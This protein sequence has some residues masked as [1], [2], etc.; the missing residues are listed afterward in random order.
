MLRF[1][2]IVLVALS[3]GVAVLGQEQGPDPYSMKFVQNNLRIALASG[4]GEWAGAGKGFQRLGDAV[5]IA[6]VKILS[7]QDLRNP[8]VVRRFLPIIRQS[9]SYPSAISVEADKDPKVTLF[10]LGD[11]EQ[12]VS[13]S[14]L[15]QQIH[16][17]ISFIKQQTQK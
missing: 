6:L 4:G 14:A 8:D 13:E 16:E 11:L 10:L 17:T 7:E 1:S 12:R 3:I 9:F 15:R 2:T 5:S